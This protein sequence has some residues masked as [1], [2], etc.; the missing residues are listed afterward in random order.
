MLCENGTAL[1]NAWTEKGF[2]QDTLQILK[3]RQH[4]I[5]ENHSTMGAAQSILIHNNI[6]TGATD[7]RIIGGTVL[8]Y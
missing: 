7:S 3:K 6:F 1:L 8:G 2:N 4:K 5:T